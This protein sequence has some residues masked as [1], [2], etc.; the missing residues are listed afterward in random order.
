M[1]TYPWTL[2]YINELQAELDATHRALKDI[3]AYPKEPWAQAAARTVLAKAAH[4]W[5]PAKERLSD[6]GVSIT[7]QSMK[8][9]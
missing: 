2:D 6:V 7:V 8:G 9:G 4:K 5:K 3:V 1:T